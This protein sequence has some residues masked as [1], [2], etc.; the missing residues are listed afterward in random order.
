VVG[1]PLRDPEFPRK[2]VDFIDRIVGAVRDRTTRP[3]VAVT[4]GVVFGSLIAV[5]SIALVA[6]FLIAVMRG[7]QELFEVVLSERRAVW[8]S[9]FVVGAA[10]ILVG[11][12]LL[13]ARHSDEKEQP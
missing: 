9:Y 12:F 4:R 6:L 10:F 3:I 8:V 13:R 1:N 2:T 11:A 7:V 5:V